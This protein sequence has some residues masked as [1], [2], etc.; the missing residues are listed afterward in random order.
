[1]APCVSFASSSEA[2]DYDEAQSKK[3]EMCRAYASSTTHTFSGTPARS[4]VALSPSCTHIHR[5]QEATMDVR[6]SAA[7]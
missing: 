4:L 2:S 7:I 6:S 1:M 5:P 3:A